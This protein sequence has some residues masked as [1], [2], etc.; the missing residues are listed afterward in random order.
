MNSYI[1]NK[2]YTIYK[3]TLSNKELD[4]LKNELTV[5]PFSQMTIG[6]PATKFQVF[7]ENT[8]KIYIPRFFG[9][10][11]FGIPKNNKLKTGNDI[12]INFNGDLREYQYNIINTFMN[13]VNN[14]NIGGL[15][16][17]P[18]G[19]GKTVMALNIISK[20]K[21]KT[22][23]I[24]HKSFLLNQWVERIKQ[25][26]PDASIGIIQGQTIDVENKDIVIGMLQSLSMKNYDTTLFDCFGLTII[27][28]VHHIAA[29]VFVRS[30]FKIVSPIMLGLSATMN[31]KDGLSFVFK[32]FL[33]PVIYKEKRDVDDNVL[34]KVYQYH[35]DDEE[36]NDIVYDYKGNPQYSTMISKLCNYEPRSEYIISILKTII[37]QDID[38]KEQII[39][40]AHNRNVLTYIYEAIYDRKIASVGYY[41]GGMKEEY[42]KQS[43]TKKIVIGTY[44]MASEAL[45]IK[46]LTTLVMVTPKTDIEQSVGRILRAKHSQ[47]LVVDI[48]DQHTVFKKQFKKRLTFYRKNKYKVIETKNT[49]V[50]EQN[51]NWNTLYDPNDPKTI[52]KA[53][54]KNKVN[55]SILETLGIDEDL[56]INKSK[57]FINLD[58]I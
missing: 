34:V 11:R 4:D 27:D 44:S 31:R 39:L 29:E 24:V 6:K 53:N 18:C 15:L 56:H 33:G 51:I 49:N 36:F 40:L 1:G 25:F 13:S 43:E 16:E 58:N 10:E 12:S 32:M 22:L 45:D 55:N 21:K 48:V 26:L 38:N 41:L 2:G 5:S 46:T 42:L 7:R 19:R 37:K 17:I 3:K 50:N 20:I 30:L 9:I 23:V 47:P 8:E 14:N 35:T 52:T 57:C 28:E 54:N